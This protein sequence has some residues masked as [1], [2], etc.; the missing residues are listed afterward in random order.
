MLAPREVSIYL[1][2]ALKAKH[3]LAELDSDTPLPEV[4]HDMPQKVAGHFVGLDEPTIAEI[5]A[6]WKLVMKPNETPVIYDFKFDPAS[7]NFTAR[8][9]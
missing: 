6:A 9:R 3:V 4:I 7:G 1:N 8:R 5:T 2:N